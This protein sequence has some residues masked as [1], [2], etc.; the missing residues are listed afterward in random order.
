MDVRSSGK[1]LSCVTT[2]GMGTI[3]TWIAIC[4][5][6]GATPNRAAELTVIWDCQDIA[7]TKQRVKPMKDFLRVVE[8]SIRLAYSR[9]H[10]LQQLAERT[11]L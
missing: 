11:V 7:T 8:F 2:D 10:D 6:L 4:K 3:T 1:V 5:M 9:N